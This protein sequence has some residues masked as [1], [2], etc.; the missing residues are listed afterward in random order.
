MPLA[1][2]IAFRTKRTVCDAIYLSP[3]GREQYEMVTADQKLYRTLQAGP[4]V[5]RTK[6]AEGLV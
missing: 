3:A 4:L 6:W 1:L 5:S 2:E